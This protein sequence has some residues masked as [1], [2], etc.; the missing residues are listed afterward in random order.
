MGI[1]RG[2]RSRRGS[3]NSI[4][5]LLVASFTLGVL[6]VVF[7]V[8]PHLSP[9]ETKVA[10]ESESANQSTLSKRDSADL[11][12]PIQAKAETEAGPAPVQRAPTPLNARAVDESPAVPW[13]LYIAAI[14]GVLSLFANGALWLSHQRMAGDIRRTHRMRDGRDA[15]P[16]PAPIANPSLGELPESWRREIRWLQE[17]VQRTVEEVGTLRSQV[18]ELGRQVAR[19]SGRQPSP[20]LAETPVSSLVSTPPV[21]NPSWPSAPME[22]RNVAAHGREH[23]VAGTL[24]RDELVRASPASRPMIRIHWRDGAAS[25]EVWVNPD[26]KF[27]DLTADL[28]DTAFVVEGG[29]PGA[30]ETVTPAII[31]WGANASEGRLKRRGVVRPRL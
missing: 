3:T 9:P 13:W 25:A 1:I 30:Y 7:V 12:G 11:Q 6:A 5:L 26:F 31:E 19:H 24:S 14:L 16:D 17:G 20:S 28:L 8:R 29:G 21:A 4:L 23:I 27:A 22:T 15:L 10:S 18:E 2:K